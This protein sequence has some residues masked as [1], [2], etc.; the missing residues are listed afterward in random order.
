MATKSKAS[1][2]SF[3]LMTVQILVLQS[4]YILAAN[5]NS[6][7]S[8]RDTFVKTESTESNNHNI[9]KQ[10]K[11]LKY[12]HREENVQNGGMDLTEGTNST[13]IISDAED[14]FLCPD[15]I[16]NCQDGSKCC[17]ADGD[18]LYNCC[19]ISDVRNDFIGFEIIKNLYIQIV[20]S[21]LNNNCLTPLFF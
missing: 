12:K 1:R 5:L 21:T 20:L 6:V 16:N 8:S 3:I 19:P 14:W 15:G 10:I 17:D 11:P 9:L 13:F 7:R 2:A 18:G 4:T